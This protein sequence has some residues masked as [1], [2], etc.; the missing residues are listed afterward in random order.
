LADKLFEKVPPHNLEA[1]RAVLGDC[2]LDA[3]ALTLAVD[4]L[5]SDDFYDAVHRLVFEV[6]CEMSSKS[7][8]V[9][10]LTIM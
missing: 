1:E 9:D 6:I 5:R 7:K 2:L 4:S 8:E 10:P 3:D